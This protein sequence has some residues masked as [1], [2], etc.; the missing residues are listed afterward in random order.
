VT[1]VSVARPRDGNAI[2]ALL[3]GGKP[4]HF[5]AGGTDMLIAGRQPPQDGIVVDL[6]RA[7]DLRGVTVAGGEIRI[8]AAT[9]VA[10]LADDP[11]LLAALPALAQAAAQCGAVQIR[12]RATIG[13]NIAQG[14]PAADLLPP[15]WAADARLEI[16]DRDGP[17]LVEIKD[18]TAAPGA[19]IAAILLPVI[20][21]APHSGFAKLGARR[22][23]TIAKINLAVLMWRDGP[24]IADLRIVAGALGPRPIR[25]HRAEAALTGTTL[26]R[27]ALLRFAEALTQEV[28]AAIP[29]RS[30]RAWKRR[31]IVG[32]GLDVVAG[33]TGHSP[34]DQLFAGGD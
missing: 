28:D 31:A 6:A 33:L 24:R 25:L 20:D 32:L 21:P 26:S 11:V 34:R 10:R 12:N 1:G 2:R 8:G 27:P 17:H 3:A 29:D 23:L 9:T 22:E 30:S 16:W 4:L 5:I 13:G 15:L 18:F 7:A 19:L 14:A